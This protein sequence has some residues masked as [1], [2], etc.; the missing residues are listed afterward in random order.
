VLDFLAT[1]RADKQKLIA[2]AVAFLVIV[3]VDFSF[4]L[5]AQVKSL[6][7][8]KVKTTKLQADIL[9]VKRDMAAMQ[10]NQAKAKPSRPVKRI[11]SEG[12]LLTLLES[13][14]GIAKNDAVRVSQI[15][16]QKSPRPPVRAGQ[17][18]SPFIAVGIKLDLTCGYHSLGTFINDLENNEYAV[19]VEDVKI[20]P[21]FSGGSQRVRVNLTLKTY[22]KS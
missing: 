9:A 22:V 17:Q 8:V 2:V 7:D 5:K 13:V 6:T 16:P 20:T 21:D 3:Y 10:Q 1:I 4:V 18:Q 19:S 14:S 15:N 12:E 11:V